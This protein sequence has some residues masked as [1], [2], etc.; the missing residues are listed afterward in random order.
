MTNPPRIHDQHEQHYVSL[1]RTVSMDGF[2]DV[3][4]AG[5]PELFGWLGQRG[6]APESAP[7]IRYNRIDMA[8]TLDIELAVP[9]SPGDATGLHGDDRVTVGSLPAGRYATLHHVGPYDGLM[10]SNA[11]LQEWAAHNGVAFDV[12]PS[13][14]GDRWGARVEIYTTNPAEEPDPSKLEV[15]VSYRLAG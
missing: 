15:E 12:T 14:S 13:S 1:S 5:F 8:G 6:V 2:S 9:V 10:A 11:A 3:I 4:D 7:F